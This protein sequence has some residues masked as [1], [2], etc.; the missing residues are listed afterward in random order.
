MFLI[1]IFS[2]LCQKNYGVEDEAGIF[3]PGN[4]NET[5]KLRCRRES[6]N[7]AV[8]LYPIYKIHPI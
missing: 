2:L 5:N 4:V 6:C 3:C 8:K 7:E 1:E